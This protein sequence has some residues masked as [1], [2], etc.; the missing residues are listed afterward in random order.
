MRHEN[1]LLVFLK[2]FSS[3][4]SRRGKQLERLS[5][6]IVGILISYKLISVPAIHRNIGMGTSTSA[7]RVGSFLSPYVVFS[8]RLSYFE[9]TC[10]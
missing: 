3:L 9:V 6:S 1:L 4:H 7:A 10:H 5:S 2:I 8:V